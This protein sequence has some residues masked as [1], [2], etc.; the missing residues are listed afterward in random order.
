MRPASASCAA[1]NNVPV[2]GDEPEPEPRG[3]RAGQHGRP[4]DRRQRLE[5]AVPV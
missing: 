5:A 4:G 2:V 1:T 3:L